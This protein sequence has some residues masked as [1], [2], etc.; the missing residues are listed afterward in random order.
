MFEFLI[1]IGFLG[2]RDT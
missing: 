2:W 1:I